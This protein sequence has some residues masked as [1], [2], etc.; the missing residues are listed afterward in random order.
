MVV[1]DLDDGEDVGG[2]Q[3]RPDREEAFARRIENAAAVS[4]VPSPSSS[5][6]KKRW[7]FSEPTVSSSDDGAGTARAAGVPLATGLLSGSRVYVRK[8]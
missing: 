3:E 1:L 8:P 2:A 4:V 5:A 6:S 7:R